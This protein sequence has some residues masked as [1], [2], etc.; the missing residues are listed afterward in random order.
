MNSISAPKCPR[1]STILLSRENEFF[2][3]WKCHWIGQIDKRTFCAI[4]DAPILESD[5]KTIRLVRIEDCVF[6]DGLF[7]ACNPTVAWHDDR[8]WLLVRFVNYT[9]QSTSEGPFFSHNI[10]C[11]LDPSLSDVRLHP[12]RSTIVQLREPDMVS[13][14]THCRGF[15]DVRLFSHAG[16][17]RGIACACDYNPQG[18][19]EQ[20]TFDV[21]PERGTIYNA[22]VRRSPLSEK[23]WLPLVEPDR[24]LYVYALRPTTIM[25]DH[26]C[27][28]FSRQHCPEG[29]VANQPLLSGGSQAVPFLGGYLLVAHERFRS[30]SSQYY[31][32]RFVHL[33][34]RMQVLSISKPFSFRHHGVEFC[35]GMAPLKDRMLV[36]FG[37]EDR[38]AWL[39]EISNAYIERLLHE[40]RSSERPR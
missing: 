21:D 22:R 27:R 23:N 16:R 10:M 32:H 35:C 20:V 6:G 3:C 14:E 36:S 11:D 37:I 19:P 18:R 34:D 24:L 38:E 30:G 39:C 26:D 1:C 28:E 7:H 9:L 40:P 17:M 31:L 33:S 4:P 25:L 13:H 8:L 15:E 2:R 5:C 29:Q 12:E